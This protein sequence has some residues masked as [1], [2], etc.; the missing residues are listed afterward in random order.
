MNKLIFGAL[1]SVLMLSA[2]GAF[3]QS[4]APIITDTT[5]HTTYVPIGF[6]D[7]DRVELMIEGLFSNSCYK[8]GPYQVDV[9]KTAKSIKINQSAYKYQGFCLEMLVPFS[10]V[11]YVGLLDAGVYTVVD[12][13]TG[14]EKGS[15][16]VVKSSNLGPDDH[17]YAPVSDAFATRNGKVSVTLNGTF[18]NSCLKVTDVKASLNN[19]NVILVQPIAE[20][21]GSVCDE[22]KF[23]YQ[24]TKEIEAD[25]DPGRY[26]LHVR[27]LNGQAINKLLDL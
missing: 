2:P 22:G 18:T 19:S 12:A 24:V 17:L 9:D 13:S 25:I 10:Q 14:T 26:L 11:V 15:L 8:V 21:S 23:P 5:I 1:T 16:P 4:T 20:K 7:N 27:S 6:D 3:A